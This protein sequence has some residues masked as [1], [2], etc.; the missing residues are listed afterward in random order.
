MERNWND[1]KA[2]HSNLAGARDAF[3]EACEYLFRETYSGKN[4]QQVKVNHGDGG[5]DVY[6][7]YYQVEPIDVIQC[8]FFLDEF[9]N[10]QV[11]QLNKSFSTSMESKDYK[12]RKWT[13]CIPKVLN[14]EETERWSRWKKRQEGKY[15]LKK[16]FIQLINGNE[17]IRRMKKQNVYSEVFKITEAKK[18]DQILKAVKPGDYKE[19]NLRVETKNNLSELE[20]FFNQEGLSINDALREDISKLF[21]ELGYNAFEYGNAKNCFIDINEE[22]I[23]FQEDGRTF[24]YIDAKDVKKRAG[25]NFLDILISK[26]SEICEFTFEPSSEQSNFNIVRLKFKQKISHTNIGDP[27]YHFI[28]GSIYQRTYIQSLNFDICDDCDRII[29][30]LTGA[31]LVPSSMISFIEYIDRITKDTDCK[32]VIKFKP[33]DS[34]KDVTRIILTDHYPHLTNKISVE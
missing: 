18:I 11:Q 19:S 14:Q 2:I 33:L 31:R 20:T 29:F 30:D 7:G 9:E 10:A 16:D 32:L 24:N 22:E 34:V 6:I 4:V 13:L 3:E 15:N 8:K 21:L 28:F 23:L 25:L 27:C 17:L 26:Y 12:L 5:I 1:F